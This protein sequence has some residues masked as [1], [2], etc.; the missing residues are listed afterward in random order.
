MFCFRLFY[1]YTVIISNHQIFFKLSFSPFGLFISPNFTKVVK[2]RKIFNFYLLSMMF[3]FQ[4]KLNRPE[5]DIQN[6]CRILNLLKSDKILI[7]L[8]SSY[9]DKEIISNHQIFLRKKLM[10]SSASS[11]ASQPLVGCQKTWK[12]KQVTHDS[13]LRVHFP[14]LLLPLVLK[15]RHQLFSSFRHPQRV[16]T[17]DPMVTTL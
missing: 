14:E 7:L 10:C 4:N 15:L 6:M 13:Q 17:Y 2:N 1:K 9:K 11:C 3:Q 5:L 8:I 16:W 12:L